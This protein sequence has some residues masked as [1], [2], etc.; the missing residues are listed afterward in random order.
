MYSFL[1]EGEFLQITIEDA[2]QVTGFVSRYGD[3]DSDR[4]TFIDQF[5]KEGKRDGTRLTFAT[6]TVHSV[7]Y[8]FHGAFERGSGKTH[9]DE[10]YYLLKGTLTEFREAADKKVTANPRAVTFKSFPQDRG[11][12][13]PPGD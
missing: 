1:K 3:G 7:W 4:G 8:E 6:K 12:T 5:F 13:S 2:G 10:A 9:D 11:A